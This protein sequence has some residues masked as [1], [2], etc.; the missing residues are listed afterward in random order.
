V[1]RKRTSSVFYGERK[2]SRSLGPPAAVYLALLELTG[3]LKTR[4]AQTGQTPVSAYSVVLGC[5]KW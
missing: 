1:Q 4:Y 3:S 2:G 5:V